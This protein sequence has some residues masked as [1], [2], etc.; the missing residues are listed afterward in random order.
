MSVARGNRTTISDH[1][2]RFIG[3][4]DSPINTIGD[5]VMRLRSR[6]PSSLPALANYRVKSLA[7]GFG[8][9]RDNL[10]AAELDRQ[11]ATSASSSLYDYYRPSSTLVSHDDAS[12]SRARRMEKVLERQE[13][14]I[15]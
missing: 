8:H 7:E 11:V 4:K 5:R 6:E 2:T 13:L 3:L 10:E 15:A 14:Q 1:S 9:F 12:R